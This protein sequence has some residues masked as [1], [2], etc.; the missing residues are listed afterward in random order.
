MRP[1]GSGRGRWLPFVAEGQR[2][3]LPVPSPVAGAGR[4][5]PLTPVL[6]VHDRYE[7]GSGSVE[8]Q[9]LSGDCDYRGHEEPLATDEERHRQQVPVADSEHGLNLRPG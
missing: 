4:L 8:M 3:G 9:P 7:P 6:H 1:A 5:G 2:C